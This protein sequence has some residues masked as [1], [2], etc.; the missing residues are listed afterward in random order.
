[1]LLKKAK[2]AIETRQL[3][4]AGNNSKKL[5]QAI[6]TIFNSSKPKPLPKQLLQLASTPQD[7][8]NQVNS[9]FANVGKT[10]AKNILGKQQQLYVD[11]SV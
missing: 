8:V 3:S 1:M 9:N 11:L 5:W 10:S 2:R 6:K 4:D 7:A